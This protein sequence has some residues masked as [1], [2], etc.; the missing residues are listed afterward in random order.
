[1]RD[2]ITFVIIGAIYLATLYV[3][4]RPNSTGPQIIQ[5]VLATFGDLVRGVAGQ[6]YNS[7][8]GQWSTNA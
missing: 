7:Q 4:V 1:M 3:L 5:N 8:T 2:S 6:T